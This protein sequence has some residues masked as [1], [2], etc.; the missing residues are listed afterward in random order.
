MK[1]KKRILSTKNLVA[2][3][4]WESN[5]PPF[6]MKSW[7]VAAVPSTQPANMRIARCQSRGQQRCID[8]ANH[9]KNMDCLSTCNTLSVTR[10]MAVTVQTSLTL[11]NF[12]TYH[13]VYTTDVMA[14]ARNWPLS[15]Q[16]NLWF[17]RVYCLKELSI[18][19]QCSPVTSLTVLYEWCIVRI[20]MI[21]T[22]Q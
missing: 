12:T 4:L 15:L 14:G 17:W 13:Y 3:G 18:S 11:W 7:D 21:V 6:T 10:A 2:P 1:M 19:F 16:L 8:F 9:Q 22:M 20:N 5:Q